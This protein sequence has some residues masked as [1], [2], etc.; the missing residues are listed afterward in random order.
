MMDGPLNIR[1]AAYAAKLRELEFPYAEAYDDLVARLYAGEIGARA[2]NAGEL[3]PP[4]ILPS[5]AGVLVSLDELTARGPVVISFNR[6]HWC[7]FCKIELRTIASYHQELSAQGAH[8]VTIMPDRQQFVEDIRQ[9][10]LNR[11]EILTD[12]DNGY[13]LSLGLA[14]WLGKTVTDLMRGHGYQL[15]TYQGNDGWFVP[16]PATFVVG[17]DG[18]VI[19]RFVDPDFRKR[20]EVTDI[21]AALKSAAG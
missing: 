20:M 3:M 16:V 17:R 11:I 2:P 13:A 14:M 4:F 10:T 8:I 9:V 6:G 12:M 7:P 21:I 5:K 19:T 18:L 15:E 1:L